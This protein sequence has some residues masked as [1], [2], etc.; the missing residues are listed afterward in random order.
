M[1]KFRI[2]CSEPLISAKETKQL[3]IIHCIYS[4][5]T[6]NLLSIYSQFTINVYTLSEFNELKFHKTDYWRLV[7]NEL[8][9][10]LTLRENKLF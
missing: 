3:Q 5:F 6:L 9:I 1:L 7:A 2:V 10:A 4:Q 8:S